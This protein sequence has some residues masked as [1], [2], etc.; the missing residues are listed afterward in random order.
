MHDLDFAGNHVLSMRKY[1]NYNRLALVLN[2]KSVRCLKTHHTEKSSNESFVKSM[3]SLI[4]SNAPL[5]TQILA[6]MPSI[7]II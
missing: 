4:N 2:L 6:K 3:N 7:Y 5:F 1:C